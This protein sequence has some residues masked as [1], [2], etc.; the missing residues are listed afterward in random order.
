MPT[1]KSI[2]FLKVRFWCR[3]RESPPSLR[4]GGQ[5]TLTHEITCI[6]TTT[7]E[8]IL[9]KISDFD[10]RLRAAAKRR[11][12][13]KQNFLYD[14]FFARATNFLLKGKRKFCF[15]RSALIKQAEAC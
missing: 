9:A 10:E 13:L 7:L 12:R 11:L 6:Y 5:E 15:R 4:Y 14:S 8:P 1:K 2:N 3:G